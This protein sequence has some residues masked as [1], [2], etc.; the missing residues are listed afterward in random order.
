MLLTCAEDRA[1]HAASAPGRPRST[2]SAQSSRQ[3][4][5]WG[6][7]S[8]A[9]ARCPG[10]PGARNDRLRG[11]RDSPKGEVDGLVEAECHPAGV[12]PLELLTAEGPAC[13][14]EAFLA[15]ALVAGFPRGACLFRQ[16]LRDAVQRGCT[17]PVPQ[18]GGQ[19]RQP[20]DGAGARPRFS[21]RLF[22]QSAGLLQPGRNA[23]VRRRARRCIPRLPARCTGGLARA[24]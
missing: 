21:R 1:Q 24:G 6:T 19:A 9:N 13:L 11:W 7:A 2:I 18:V 10:E 16:G 8:R 5:G 4:G 14:V 17:V 3:P 23:A 15:T 12:G 22:L 20:D